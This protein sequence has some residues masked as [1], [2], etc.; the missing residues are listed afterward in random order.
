MVIRIW[1]TKIDETRAEDYLQFAQ[2][3]SVPMFRA[4]PG[5]AGVVFAARGAE[6]AVITVWHDLAAAEALEHSST[7]SS[8]VAEIEA[9]GLLRGESSVD[10]LDVQGALFETGRSGLGA[11]QPPDGRR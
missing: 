7:Y 2:S 5:F 3:R 4:Q 8:T 11:A 6:R 10:V 1:H 9:T